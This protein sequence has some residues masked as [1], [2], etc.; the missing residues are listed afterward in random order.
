MFLSVPW[1]V[2]AKE[3]SEIQDEGQTVVVRNIGSRE[4]FTNGQGQ[5]RRVFPTIQQEKFMYTFGNILWRRHFNFLYLLIIFI[6]QRFTDTALPADVESDITFS[7]WGRIQGYEMILIQVI[8]DA[9]Q[10]KKSICKR[11]LGRENNN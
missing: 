11:F 2:D 1:L 7:L 8:R 3:H 4:N 6:T 5:I 9:F 10:V